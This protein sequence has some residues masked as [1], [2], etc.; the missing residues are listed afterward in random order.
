MEAAKP[1]IS[2]STPI[3]TEEKMIDIKSSNIEVNNQKYKLEF[4]KSENNKKIIFKITKN[5]NVINNYF[6]LIL[7]EEEFQNLNPIFKIY[8]NIN[9]IYTLL[10]DI[11]NDKKFNIN[12]L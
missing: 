1:I 10:I 2:I 5:S 9:D 3:D 8:Q 7:D 6:L 11:L 12:I 4:A